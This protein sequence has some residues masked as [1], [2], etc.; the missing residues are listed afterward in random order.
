MQN[1]VFRQLDRACQHMGLPCVEK[2]WRGANGMTGDS[3]RDRC[4]PILGSM[5]V[6]NKP[7]NP[8]NVFQG[9]ATANA[10]PI[11]QK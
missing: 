7:H 1:K 9:A 5:R 10:E 8:K 11:L 6:T 4:A 2:S 3:L